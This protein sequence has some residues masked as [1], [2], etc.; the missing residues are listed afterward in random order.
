MTGSGLALATGSPGS[1]SKWSVGVTSVYLCALTVRAFFVSNEGTHPFL[2]WVIM[3][4][5]FPKPEHVNVSIIV[6]GELHR[7]RLARL[8]I[9]G[10]I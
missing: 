8:V 4:P 5:A 3:Y 6:Q 2:C 1:A 7:T 9:Q 10:L